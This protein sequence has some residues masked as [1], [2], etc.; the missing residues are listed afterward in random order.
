MFAAIGVANGY[1]FSTLFLI[2]SIPSLLKPIAFCKLSCSI[3]R[4]NLGLGLPSCGFGVTV[5][6]SI[7]PKPRAVSIL[8]IVAFLSNPAASPKGFKKVLPKSFCSSLVS[9]TKYLFASSL[10]KKGQNLVPFLNANSA[11]L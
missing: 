2:F 9:V 7:C 5:P 6:N 8:I 11:T 1:S 10:S 4:N 3:W